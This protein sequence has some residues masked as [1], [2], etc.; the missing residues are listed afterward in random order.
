MM[1]LEDFHNRHKGETCLIVGVG[2][3]LDLT[4]PHWFDYPSFGVN[5]IYKSVALGKWDSWRP[6]YFVGVDERLEREDGAAI[7]D[8]YRDV[9]KFIPRPDRD[10]WQGENFHR[11]YHRPGDLMIGGQLP[12]HPDALT[13]RGIGY[14]KIM[15]AV[16]QIAWHM[17]FTTMLMI[18]VQH[19]I[20]DQQ[21][22]F[23]GQD[24]KSIP[25][26]TLH[27]WFDGY[28]EIIRS[29][30]NKIRVLNIS[31]DTY[32]PEEIIPRG[33]WRQYAKSE[34]LTRLPG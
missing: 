19:K 22:H 4:P 21:A 32:V 23:W 11:F 10:T 8:V 17:G 24:V 25:E 14:R 12:S 34:I 1:R 30:G 3:N 31:E 26:E 16:L 27:Y 2:G 15:D 33:D 29:M 20:T 5:T 28:A 9:H 6:T 13:V 7:S 18:G